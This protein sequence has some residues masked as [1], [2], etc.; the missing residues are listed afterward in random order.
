MSAQGPIQGL[1]CLYLLPQPKPT[2]FAVNVLPPVTS[3]IIWNVSCNSTFENTNIS[4][5]DNITLSLGV[6]DVTLN[7]RNIFL[8][9][10]SD[11]AVEEHDGP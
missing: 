5:S 3:P 8:I 11:D 2:P 4:A 7:I 9:K 6:P 10:T 1:Y